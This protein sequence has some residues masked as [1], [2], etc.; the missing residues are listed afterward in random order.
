MS[1]DWDILHTAT[2]SGLIA[3]KLVK[4][5]L[6]RNARLIRQRYSRLLTRSHDV[7]SEPKNELYVVKMIWMPSLEYLLRLGDASGIKQKSIVGMPNN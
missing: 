5:Q 1:F 4:I 2:P 7:S 6:C 3:M